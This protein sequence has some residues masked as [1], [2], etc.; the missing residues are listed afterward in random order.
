MSSINKSKTLKQ[1]QFRNKVDYYITFHID[2][3]TRPRIMTPYFYTCP[4]KSI[5]RALVTPQ[6]PQYAVSNSG[7]LVC[8]YIS[9]VRE[10]E[11]LSTQRGAIKGKRFISLFVDRGTG[12]LDSQE[13]RKMPFGWQYL[14]RWSFI[15]ALVV[16]CGVR[17]CLISILWTDFKEKRKTLL[18]SCCNLVFAYCASW[19]L[20]V[21]HQIEFEIAQSSRNE[22]QHHWQHTLGIRSNWSYKAQ[23]FM[24]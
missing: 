12:T 14:G 9:H 2:T 5:T 13:C 7:N 18:L 6:P 15:T 19:G 23:G 16:V 8:L 4:R 1:A 11:C 10:N 22:N 20:A 24:C 21:Y 3:R 17:K